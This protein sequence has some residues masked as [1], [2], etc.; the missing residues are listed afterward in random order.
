[1]IKTSPMTPLNKTVPRIIRG[2]ELSVS[3]VGLQAPTDRKTGLTT[4]LLAS[5]VSS[6][7]CAAASEPAK[8]PVAVILP[9]K[10]AVPMLGHPPRFSKEPK[11]SLA[12]AFGASTHKGM[13]M[14]KK[15]RKS[16][17]KSVNADAIK[18]GTPLSARAMTD[19][20]LPQR[21]KAV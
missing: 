16:V 11:T 18:D 1:M 4:V 13:M 6:A 17:M 7:K 8:E 12:G 5:R 15:R 20:V 14:Q 10:Q 9:T 2:C 3:L 19:M 21:S